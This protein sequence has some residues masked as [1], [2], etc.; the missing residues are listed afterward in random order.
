MNGPHARS[1]A[2]VCLGADRGSCESS[3]EADSQRVAL[4]LWANEAEARRD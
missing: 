4:V 2:S 1:S 3:P